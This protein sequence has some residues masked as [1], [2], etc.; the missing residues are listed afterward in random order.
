L[1]W[2]ESLSSVWGQHP[3]DKAMLTTVS[4]RGVRWLVT[5][6]CV[7]AVLVVSTWEFTRPRQEVNPPAD[8]TR[9]AENA[10]RQQL[11]V[12]RRLR[13][14]RAPKDAELIAATDQRGTTILAPERRT[15]SL[16]LRPIAHLGRP[17]VRQIARMALP[18]SAV[19]HDVGPWSRTE[20]VAALAIT[21]RGRRTTALVRSISTGTRLLATTIATVPR[22]PGAHRTYT[23]RVWSGSLGDLVVV[24]RSP[25]RGRLRTKILSGESGFTET[26]LTASTER[27]GGFPAAQF[28]LQIG[29]VSSAESRPDL[30]LITRSP[31]TGSGSLEVHVL[32]G[33][34]NYSD[35]SMQIPTSVSAWS[36]SRRQGLL[37]YDDGGPA[38]VSVDLSRGIAEVLPLD[39]FGPRKA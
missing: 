20:P 23:L 21:E 12:A 13:V 11:L 5:G 6:G 28:W 33:V 7:A 35:F 30:V 25:L 14:E 24:D 19:V 18:P 8:G 32:S 16:Y 1:G 39:H 29:P 22:D 2:T 37:A 38:I 17:V 9:G 36:G 3:C 10:R 26:L 15:N 34:S 31:R 4:K 27:G